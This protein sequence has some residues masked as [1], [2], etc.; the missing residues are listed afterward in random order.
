MEEA[1]NAIRIG[2]DMIFVMMASNVNGVIG[3][4]AYQTILKLSPENLDALAHFVTIL[5]DTKRRAC[6]YCKGDANDSHA[7][8]VSNP[9]PSSVE[10]GTIYRISIYPTSSQVL[11]L[12]KP[13]RWLIVDQEWLDENQEGFGNDVCYH[14]TDDVLTVDRKSLHT[15]AS[16]VN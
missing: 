6:W 15:S 4:P 11:A 5:A 3:D 12:A 16:R 14:V 8:D 13:D 2:D 10:I 1:M 7:M 9:Y